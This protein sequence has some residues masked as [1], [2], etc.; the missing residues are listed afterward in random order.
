MHKIRGRTFQ[1][2]QPVQR[3][4]V[5]VMIAAFN[6]TKRHTQLLRRQM[7]I[8]QDRRVTGALKPGMI[9]VCQMVFSPWG[10]HNMLLPQ[11]METVLPLLESGL[12]M[13]LVLTNRIQWKRHWA[14]PGLSSAH[15]GSICFLLFTL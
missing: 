8:V 9:D 12:A 10:A 2:G 1:L 6:R 4:Q 14:V 11:E 5:R 7:V 13:W 15:L 3:L